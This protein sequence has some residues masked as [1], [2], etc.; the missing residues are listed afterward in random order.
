MTQTILS[1]SDAPLFGPLAQHRDE[2]VLAVEVARTQPAQFRQ[3]DAG[4]VE[5][6]QDGAIAGG[7][8]VSQRADFPRRGTGD[9][10]AL[11]LLRADRAD[12]G[13][14]DLGEAHAVEGVAFYRLESH[15]P[16]EEGSRRASVGLDRALA[17]HFPPAG[18]SLAQVGKP[19]RD[20][21]G[22]H[23][24]DQRDAALLL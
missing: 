3:A 22:I 12:E 11:E 20:V 9:E 24:P 23:L 13:L 14:A 1:E 10:Q 6:P 18:R 4:I 16:V 2:A 5:H 8:A 7:S 15:Q 19:G 17:S 21:G